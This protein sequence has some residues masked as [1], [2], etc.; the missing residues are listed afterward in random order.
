MPAPRCACAWWS[1]EG[2]PGMHLGEFLGK[3]QCA[4][5]P[6]PVL[7]DISILFGT[8]QY[9]GDPRHAQLGNFRG[10]GSVSI[11]WF[12]P[13]VFHSLRLR[14]RNSPFGGGKTSKWESQ[15]RVEAPGRNFENRPGKISHVRPESAPRG[16]NRCFRLRASRE[17]I[18]EHSWVDF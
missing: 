12:Q 6:I 13:S 8:N 11:R 17:N 15:S 14:A 10:I 7:P 18:V 3:G 2:N 16:S 5:N 9:M 4:S 1:F